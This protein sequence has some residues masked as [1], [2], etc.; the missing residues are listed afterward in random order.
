MKQKKAL[1]GSSIFLISMML[2]VGCNGKGNDTTDDIKELNGQE[3]ELLTTIDASYLITTVCYACHNP[4]VGSHDEILAP[5]LVGVKQQYLKA[6]KDRD[7]FI[8]RMFAFVSSPNEENALMKGP[9]RR[10]G[11]MPKPALNEEEIKAIV[12]YVYDNQLQAPVW[13]AEHEQEMHGN[14]QN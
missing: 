12:S 10:F 1:L 13:F 5:P 7:D 14:N 3:T 4:K 11:L 8:T 6:S 2:S 9:I